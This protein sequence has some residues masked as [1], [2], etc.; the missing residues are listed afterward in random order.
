MALEDLPLV[1]DEAFATCSQQDEMD[2]LE[3]PMNASL[4]KLHVNPSRTPDSL[5]EELLVVMAEKAELELREF[6]LRRALDEENREV[7]R[8]HKIERER[9]RETERERERE[10]QRERQRDRETERQRDR[11]TERQRDRETERQR[12][13][14]TERQRDRETERQRDRETERQR[15]RETERQRDREREREREKKKKERERKPPQKRHSKKKQLVVEPPR[16]SPLNPRLHTYHSGSVSGLGLCYR[17]T[18]STMTPYPTMWG[19]WRLVS[20]T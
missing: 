9:G 3:E 4:K 14:E 10:R 15:D 8:G 18:I 12:D 5:Q 11:E 17:K 16:R 6:Q 19:F 7:A 2:R 1:S 20:R 13:R